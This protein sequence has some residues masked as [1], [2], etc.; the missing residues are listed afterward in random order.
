M[1]CAHAA[2]DARA[3]RYYEDALTRYEHKDVAGAIIQLKNALQID[4][5][6]LPVQ[7]LLGKAL[8]SNGEAANAEVAFTE[9][10][11]LGVNRAELVIA[12]ARSVVAQG[13]Q[14]QLID[15]PRFALSGLPAPVQLQL[16]LI[17][18]A[19]QSDLGDTQAALNS[20]EAA[21]AIDTKL[22][23]VWL[24]EVPIRIRARQFR[25]A[26]AAADKGLA[27]APNSA[28]GLYQKASIAHV[29][30]N[31]AAALAGYSKAL[32]IDDSHIEARLARAGIYL[33]GTRTAEAKADIAKVLTVAPRDPRGSYLNALVAEREGNA[34]ASSAA[35]HSVTALIDPIPVAFIRYRPQML[36]LNGL[37]HFGLNETEKAK[38]YLELFQS[39]QNNT[40]V[41]K[42]LAQIQLREN[43]VDRAIDLL[44][45]Y[46]KSRPN[47]AQ[48]A[49]LL[50]GAYMAKGWHAKAT[51]LMQE[52]LRNND[53]P[54]LHTVLGLSL[55]GGNKP[56]SA[57]AELETS[58]KRD[59]RQVQAGAALAALYLRDG[60]TQKAVGVA[61]ALVKQ[62]PKNASF[63]NLLGITKA[64]FHDPNGARAAFEQAVKLDAGFVQ[65]KLGLARVDILMRDFD[66]AS[67]RLTEIL[68]ADENNIDAMY[69]MA[70]LSERLGNLPDAERWLK[71][72]VDFGGPRETR[73]SFALVEL[74]LRTGHGPAAMEAAK[75][76]LTKGP[77]DVSVLIAYARAQ[78]ASGDATGARSSLANASRRADYD[79]PTQTNIASLQLAAND[80]PGAAYSLQKALSGKPDYVPALA[81]MSN[82][83]LRQGDPSK[84]EQLARQVTQANPKRALGY[85]LLGDIAVA[86][87]QPP[88][89]LEAYRRAHEL[90]PSSLSLLRLF[91]LLALRTA[92]ASNRHCS[93]PLN[94]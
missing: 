61:Q 91:G 49:S 70:V 35:L 37:A 79:A 80:L 5:T 38:Q 92:E 64:Q 8:L 4:K 40:P 88:A 33:D 68:K 69:D 73:A 36:M 72:A 93:W 53:S 83:E 75:T 47:D 1:A 3:S 55:I 66:T 17:R 51:G 77:N 50:A 26:D 76:L 2:T 28:E 87:K 52:A 78:L 19:A 16:L 90:E 54:E 30:G 82:V 65:A 57:A 43:N 84:A 60:Q 24:A 71:R 89:A 44:E 31:V 67:K 58:F 32:I 10:L 20:I 94:G 6:M 46:V 34:A 42:I 41:S 15:Q 21:R 59:P 9:A 48:G 25:E 85:N 81:L 14:A 13:K 74:H 29:Q 18:S 22:P 39:V 86:R 45:P 56:G 62:Q 7:V 63:Y 12:L 27:L 11:R 23:E